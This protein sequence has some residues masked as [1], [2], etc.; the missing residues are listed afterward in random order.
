MTAEAVPLVTRIVGLETPGG[1]MPCY[2]ALPE[3]EGNHRGMIVLQEAFGVN[4]HIQEVTRRLATEGCNPLI[5][6]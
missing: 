5:H 4:D 2:E 1:P 3:G 6:P